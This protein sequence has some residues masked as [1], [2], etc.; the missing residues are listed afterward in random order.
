MIEDLLFGQNGRNIESARIGIG[1]SWAV[2]MVVELILKPLEFRY[3]F[4]SSVYRSGLRFC[5]GK[6][7]RD[8]V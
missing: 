3:R 2:I 8:D 1:I 4:S 5:S 6:E 7:S